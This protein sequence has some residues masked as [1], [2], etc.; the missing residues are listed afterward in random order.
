AVCVQVGHE[1]DIMDSACH[2][3]LLGA[4]LVR[5]SDQGVIRFR[6]HK[7][8]ALLGYLAYHMHQAHSRDVLIAHFWPEA[9]EH[10]GRDSLSVALSALRDQ[11]E[12]PDLPAK[13]LLLADRFTVRLNPALVST[14]VEAFKTHFDAA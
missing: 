11:L 3:Q 13:A 4:L 5:Q 8:G 14:D 9:E 6:T 10:P 7:T 1:G 12:T 2:I